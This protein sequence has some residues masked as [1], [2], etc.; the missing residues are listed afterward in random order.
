[1]NFP[2][3]DD[4]CNL[5][6]AIKISL[7]TEN[8]GWFGHGFGIDIGSKI[9]TLIGKRWKESG[10]LWVQYTEEALA[11]MK[12]E[13]HCDSVSCTAFPSERSVFLKINLENSSLPVFKIEVPD[14]ISN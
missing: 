10:E 6:N 4:L 13:G 3:I 8:S 11:W 7:F 14:A 1:M 12:E 2:E 9:H 5:E